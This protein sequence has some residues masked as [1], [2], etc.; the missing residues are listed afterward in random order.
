M[1]TRESTIRRPVLV[2]LLPRPADDGGVRWYRFLLQ[3]AGG[4]RSQ[5]DFRRVNDSECVGRDMQQDKA[6]IEVQV[7]AIRVRQV[8]TLPLRLNQVTLPHVERDRL[9]GDRMRGR[10]PFSHSIRSEARD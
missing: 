1:V 10:G 6:G 8:R 2:C 7:S 5:T 9:A 3:E 4:G